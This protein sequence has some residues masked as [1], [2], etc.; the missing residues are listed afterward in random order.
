MEN[1]KE[2]EFVDLKAIERPAGGGVK[3]PHMRMILEA[4]AQVKC[5]RKT[6]ILTFLRF[7]IGHIWSPK[8]EGAFHQYVQL[9]IKKLG[10]EESCA[11]FISISISISNTNTK[12]N[13]VKMRLTKLSFNFFSFMELGWCG[14]EEQQEWGTNRGRRWT[15]KITFPKSSSIP[16]HPGIVS[17]QVRASRMEVDEQGS[18]QKGCKPSFSSSSSPLKPFFCTFG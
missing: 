2:E 6:S 1:L 17:L 13:I 7:L 12:I 15:S 11:N 4:L 3:T 18:G 16:N 9:E 8:W 5:Q 14:F 10:E